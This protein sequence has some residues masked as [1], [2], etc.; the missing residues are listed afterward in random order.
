MARML[1]KALALALILGAGGTSA[2]SAVVDEQPEIRFRRGAVGASLNGAVVRGDRDIYPITAA[3]GQ[4][5][6][7]DITSLEDNAVFQVY[8]PGTVYVRDEWDLWAFRGRPLR[9]TDGDTRTWSGVLP[10]G[11]QYLIVVGGTR[12]NAEYR[13]NVD[14]R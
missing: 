8:P 7:I 14:I 4:R 11:G 3:R 1:T 10:S 5:M 9:G 13:L 12:G 6:T 2:A